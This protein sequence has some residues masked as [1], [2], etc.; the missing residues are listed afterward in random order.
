[1]SKIVCL[2]ALFKKKCN[3][4]WSSDKLLKS[5]SS[6]AGFTIS[7]ASFRGPKSC[8]THSS[9]D[10]SICISFLYVSSYIVPVTH[11]IKIQTGTS[12]VATTGPESM[13][14]TSP[15][16]AETPKV[17]PILSLLNNL[18]FSSFSLYISPGSHL[19][20]YPSAYT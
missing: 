7:S 20:L 1:M 2:Y 9:N 10:I 5:L 17:H 6:I 8:T 11:P 15:R 3:G 18:L 19:S 12:S 13:P 16:Q 14:L 4:I